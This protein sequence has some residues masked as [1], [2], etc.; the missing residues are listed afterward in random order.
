VVN[1]HNSINDIDPLP[2]IGQKPSP[3]VVDVP[4]RLDEWLVLPGGFSINRHGQRKFGA[5]GGERDSGD[6]KMIDRDKPP[7]YPVILTNDGLRDWFERLP[8]D[9]DLP[10]KIPW[11]F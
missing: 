4:I 11:P 8:D 2:V 1:P 7:D 9:D 5:D 10:P 6:D 3:E